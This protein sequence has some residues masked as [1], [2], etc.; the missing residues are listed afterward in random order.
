M[1]FPLITVLGFVWQGGGIEPLSSFEDALEFVHAFFAMQLFF[2]WPVWGPVALIAL[3][4]GMPAWIVLLRYLTATHLSPRISILIATLF[5]VGITALG[6]DIWFIAADG[7]PLSFGSLTYS[8][9][10]GPIAAPVAA[11]ATQLVYG[12]G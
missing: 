1:T 3:L 5:V 8:T 4:I 2:G 7:L 11:I 9:V 6:A 10:F 12:F